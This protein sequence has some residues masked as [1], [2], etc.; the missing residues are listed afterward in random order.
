MNN[1]I[2]IL[3]ITPVHLVS[4]KNATNSSWIHSLYKELIKLQNVE[5][6]T[7]YPVYE[8]IISKSIWLYPIV[9][10][11]NKLFKKL[12][13][14]FKIPKYKE[15]EIIKNLDYIIGKYSPDIIHIHGTENPLFFL[16]Q[17]VKIPVVIS[18]QSILSVYEKKYY[19]GLRSIRSL[20][21][22]YPRNMVFNIL[23][24]RNY[25]LIKKLSTYEK[26]YLKDTKYLIGR[27]DWDKK[28]TSVL[29]PKARYYHCD[30]M[31]RDVFYSKII[32]NRLIGNELILTSIISKPVYKGVETLIEAFLILNKN[33]RKKVSLNIIGI[34]NNNIYFK[35][36]KSILRIT[37]SELSGIVFHGS[38]G[39]DAVYNI[40]NMSHLYIH[41]SHIENSPN[42]ICEAMMLG[43]PVI[44]SNVGGIST[45]IKNEISG[46][47][48]NSNDPY[49]LVAAIKE[50]MENIKMYSSIQIQ[51]WIDA[52]IRHNKIF[53]INRL[54]NIYYDIINERK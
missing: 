36:A 31:L 12:F 27:T 4:E 33:T 14:S 41:T 19:A 54:L 15:K 28:V 10:G 43:V 39:S 26:K 11:T 44:S 3:W 2:K 38:I 52:N 40:L 24:W 1:K 5:I 21:E 37:E 32:P 50:L 8:N 46:I 9:I 29:A 47:L 42:C 6:I 34:D 49:S 13:L 20:A 48:I 18:I 16:S 17:K 35:Y 53:I 45:L 51:A 25:F 7:I 22:L 23:F 30:E